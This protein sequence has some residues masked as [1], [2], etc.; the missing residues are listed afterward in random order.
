MTDEPGS[1]GVCVG[2]M[3][4]TSVMARGADLGRVED[5]SFPIAIF[6]LQNGAVMQSSPTKT[7]GRPAV[8]GKNAMLITH[9]YASSH[10]VAGRNPLNGVGRMA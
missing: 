1:R 8:D 3:M 9:V 7:Y 5:Q 10:H 4:S 2:M 6:R